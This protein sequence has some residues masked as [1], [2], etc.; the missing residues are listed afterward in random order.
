MTKSCCVS[1]HVERDGVYLVLDSS[2]GCLK[3]HYNRHDLLNLTQV[4][5]DKFEMLD[6]GTCYSNDT[7]I[8]VLI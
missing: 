4:G 3:A 8:K 5:H 7:L 1:G 6:I 2:A